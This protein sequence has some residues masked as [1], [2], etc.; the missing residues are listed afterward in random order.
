MPANYSIKHSSVHECAVTSQKNKIAKSVQQCI[1]YIFINA[2]IVP[3]GNYVLCFVI[4][5]VNF[6][7]TD[8]VDLIDWQAF[9]VTPPPVLRQISSHEL[10]KIQDDVPM[11]GSDF[12]KFPS[13]TQSVERIVKLVT[14]VCRK[15]VGRQNR[16]GFIRAT[17]ES[18]K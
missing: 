17:L 6:G 10:L 8:Y 5:S 14:E 16:D 7:A 11:D 12:I 3:E 13:H 4:P 9:Y 1:G 18:R 2:E 15:K